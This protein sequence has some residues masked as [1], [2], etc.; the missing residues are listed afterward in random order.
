[1]GATK[2]KEMIINEEFIRSYEQREKLKKKY[3]AK[4]SENGNA[5]EIEMCKRKAD[6]MDI[7]VNEMWKYVR[8]CDAHREFIQKEKD[9][10]R[11]DYEELVDKFRHGN[12]AL[13]DKVDE[14]RNENQ[15]L[16]NKVEENHLEYLAMKCKIDEDRQKNQALTEKVD[17]LTEMFVKCLNDPRSNPVVNVQVG[18][19]NSMQTE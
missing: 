11:K 1:M 19:K 13:T 12:K 10:C 16:K 3:E 15:D 8:K 7:K 6:K 14:Y 9:E 17:L 18:S 5:E 4:K 2:S